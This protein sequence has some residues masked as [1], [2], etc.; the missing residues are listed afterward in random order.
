MLSYPASETVEAGNCGVCLC[1]A[2]NKVEFVEFDVGNV[3]TIS[4]ESSSH[5]H[6]STFKEIM[7]FICGSCQNEIRPM[8][9][10]Y[11]EDITKLRDEN[12]TMILKK[13]YRRYQHR[14]Q[15]Y[16]EHSRSGQILI[17]LQSIL[18]LQRQ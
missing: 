11:P 12:G 1:L 3:C 18:Y 15:L 2:L 17:D 14:T 5:F 9:S 4:L 10:I 6:L 16:T 8:P 13:L 7:N